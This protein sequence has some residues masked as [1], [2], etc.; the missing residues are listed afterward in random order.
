MDENERVPR[1]ILEEGTECQHLPATELFYG[2]RADSNLFI[3]AS[4]PKSA[5]SR[6]FEMNSN[7]QRYFRIP[8]V[9]PSASSASASGDLT[10]GK[11]GLWY[12]HFDGQYVARQ[13]ELH[14][15]KP[16]ILLVAGE[17]G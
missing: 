11:R 10:S 8:F 3:A 9:R 16:P 4:K 17:Y 1:S 2:K 5:G 7:S 6:K 14:P 12:A 13:M 15:E